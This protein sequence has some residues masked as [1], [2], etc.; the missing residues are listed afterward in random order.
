MSGIVGAPNTIDLEHLDDHRLST[1]AYR[2]A[3]YWAME[4]LRD[5]N[6]A[7][8][9]HLFQDARRIVLQWLRSDNVV[10][11]GG[12]K[13]AQLQY[14]QLTDEVCDLL[15]GALL[16]Q[17]NGTP[18]IRAT[19]DPFSPEGSTMGVSFTTSKTSRHSPR[20]DKSHINW[21]ITDSDW[22]TRFAQ[23]VENH[24][25]VTSYAKNHNLGLEVPYLMEGEPHRYLPDYLIRLDN[26][27]PTTLV[28]EV[29]GFRGHDAML[30][31]QTMQNK[32]IPAVNRLGR[33][34][35]WGFAELRAV[36]DFKPDLD[37]AI[38]ALTSKVAHA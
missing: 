13:L 22:E 19:L 12:T 8:K 3:S 10:C 33:F 11:K 6:Q 31:A 25:R 24:P 2:I 32:W 20:P 21:I 4:K 29:K 36:H 7:P 34:G 9:P 35:R 17:P 15:M 37:A 16:D 38:D 1:I 28:V 14:R 30:K 27:E 26:D 23:V 5:P 18:I